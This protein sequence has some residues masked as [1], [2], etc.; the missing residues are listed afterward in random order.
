MEEEEED[1]EKW[2]SKSKEECEHMMRKIMEK[3]K[4]IF[5][6]EIREI[7]KVKAISE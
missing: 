5:I 7:F 2:K 3:I 4:I 1:L 6:A